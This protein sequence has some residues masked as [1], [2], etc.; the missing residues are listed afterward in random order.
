MLSLSGS[1]SAEY[2]NDGSF[3]PLQGFTMFLAG[4]VVFRVFFALLYVC[5]WKFRYCCK[6]K[7]KVN[8]YSLEETF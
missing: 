1:D 7:Y 6:D 2:V 8:T 5:K 3:G 4:I